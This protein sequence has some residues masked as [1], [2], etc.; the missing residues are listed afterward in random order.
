MPM[1][2]GASC[3]YLL[4]MNRV[5]SIVSLSLATAFGTGIASAEDKSLPGVSK[6]EPIVTA[7]PPEPDEHASDPRSFRVGNTDVRISG[8]V[9]VDVTIGGIGPSPRR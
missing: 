1:A 3:T 8:E 7:P 4:R 2:N 5:A 9:V 6:P